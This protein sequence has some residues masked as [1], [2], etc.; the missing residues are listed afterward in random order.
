MDP[1]LLVRGALLGFSIAAPVGPIGV[2]CIRRALADGWRSGFVTGLGAATADAFYGAVAAFGLTLISALLVA[3]QGWLRLVGGLF[4]CYLGLRTLRAT[5]AREAAA[6]SPLSARGALAMYA[7]TV[8]LTLTNPLTILS[9]VAVFAGLGLGGT[10][11]SYAGAALVVLGV[12]TGSALWW[13]L[14]SGT[15]GALRSRF[16]VEVLVWANRVS[17]AI[18]LAF[19][20]L[21]LLSLVL[22]LVLGLVS[23]QR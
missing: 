2:L 11:R 18:L 19:G 12:F 23:T 5:P 3:E 7:S 9:F 8:L 1:L 6:T 22:G 20:L 13:L 10:N 16:R 14:L 21:A 4:L 15:V 17:G